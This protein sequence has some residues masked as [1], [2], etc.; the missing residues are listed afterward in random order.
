MCVCDIFPLN[1]V[2]ANVP[3]LCLLFHSATEEELTYM[4]DKCFEPHLKMQHVPCPCDRDVEVAMFYDCASSTQ[5]LRAEHLRDD[6]PG[7]G[8]SRG[9]KRGWLMRPFPLLCHCSELAAG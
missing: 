4:S 5:G 7:G 6:N 2:L 3:L 1:P 9:G 8:K